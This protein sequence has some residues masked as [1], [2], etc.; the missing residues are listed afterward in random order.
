MKICSCCKAEKSE[1][2]FYSGRQK[3]KKCVITCARDYA[4][5]NAGRVRAYQKKYHAENYVL[6]KDEILAAN[7]SWKSSNIERSRAYHKNYSRTQYH[8]NPE[9]KMRR[10]LANRLGKALEGKKKSSKTLELLGCSLDS[11]REHLEK[12]FQPGMTWKNHNK[13]GWH[14]DH[15]RPCADF[16]LTDPAQQ[17]ACFHFSNLQPLWAIDNFKKGAKC[18]GNNLTSE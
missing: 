11:L 16:D 13:A 4:V 12:Q 7:K 15:K 14:I 9:F 17:R 3:C 10:N 2:E 1:G 6:N 8:K 18:G 5:A